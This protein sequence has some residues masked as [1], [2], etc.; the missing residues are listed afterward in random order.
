MTSSKL[1]NEL[2]LHIHRYCDIDT[3]LAI[4]KAMQWHGVASYKMDTKHINELEIKL[5]FKKARSINFFGDM[6]MFIEI[7]ICSRKVYLITK[8]M[9]EK[10]SDVCMVV[11]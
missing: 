3:R 5:R 8:T 6:I 10:K 9:D 4:Q 11:W 7:P 2:I 1:P